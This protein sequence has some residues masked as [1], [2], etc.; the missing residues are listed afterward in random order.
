MNRLYKWKPLAKRSQGQPI[1]RHSTTVPQYN[2]FPGWVLL[3]HDEEG[4][5]RALFVDTHGRSEALSVVMD[6]RVCC[7]TVFRAI[8]V[9]PRIIVLHDLWTLNGDT[10]WVRT[11]WETRQTWIRELL[12]FFHVPVLT[13]L[14]SLDGVPV[15]T[16]VRGYESYDTLPG[17]LGVFTEDLPHKE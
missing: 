11:A 7:D 9:S 5:A 3:T 12:S 8:K 10:V 17:T 14:V 6:E 15:G 1:S 16:L 4:T 2:G 13:A